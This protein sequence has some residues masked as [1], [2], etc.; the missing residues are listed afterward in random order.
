TRIPYELAGFAAGLPL[1]NHLILV[2][3]LISYLI[4]GCIMD[5][6]AMIVLTVPIFYPVILELGFDPVWFG[7]IMVIVM[8]MALITP[9]V[10]M[11]VFAIAGVSKDVPLYTIFRGILPFL[12]A[13][14]VCIALIVAF[15]EIATFLPSTM[16]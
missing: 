7:V 2:F 16:T 10:G 14:V 6:I 15:P 11:N 5:A 1:S 12:I 9:P 3:I 8:E 4:L 13:M